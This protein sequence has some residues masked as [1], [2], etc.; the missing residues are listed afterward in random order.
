MSRKAENRRVRGI[1]AV[2]LAGGES[3]RLGVD[4]ALLEL[5]GQSLLART[6]HR[7]A[8][9]SD[10]TIVVTNHF[11]RYEH[12]ALKV[13]FV[14]DEQPGEGALMGLYSGLR[15]ARY[16]SAL[17]VACDMPFLNLS[18][19]RYMVARRVGYDVV[20]PRL[21]DDM[22]EPLHAIYSK[23]CLPLMAESLADGRRRI[24]AFF[25]KVSVYY[26]ERPTIAQFDP[27]HRT[28][29]NVNTPADWQLVQDLFAQQ[30]LQ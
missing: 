17:A 2:V 5:G 26:V 4:K 29:V 27:L 28:F 9:I 19:L 25:D 16:G 23:R 8:T 13:R 21:E 18:L 1:S 24:M 6:V 22:L 7:L 15:E 11:E 30:E 10:D 20:V 3:H 14:L 12:L